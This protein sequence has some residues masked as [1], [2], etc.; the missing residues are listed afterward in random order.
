MDTLPTPLYYLGLGQC[1]KFG[2]FDA[3][4]TKQL[5]GQLT[6]EKELALCPQSDYV[7]LSY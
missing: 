4:H 7:G 3:L 1:Y 5:Q 6:L 2:N